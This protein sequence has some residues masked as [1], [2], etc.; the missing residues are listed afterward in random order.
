MTTP[1]STNTN[2]ITNYSA[3]D[4]ERIINDFYSPTS[5][6]STEQ[7]QKLNTILE[8][9]Q[10]SKSAWDFPWKFL[11]ISKS[12]S[13]QFFGTVALCN[14]ISKHL[15]ELDD[16]QIREL[17]HQLIQR[18]ILYISINSKQIITKLTIVVS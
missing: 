5:Q 17:F 6:L 7:R 12:S 16:N 11:D 4:I 2:V 18:L 14:K 9:L 1:I 13:I 3:E 10:Y 15:L 8:N